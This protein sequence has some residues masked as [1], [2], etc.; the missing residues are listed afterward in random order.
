[1]EPTDKT[2][3]T[4]DDNVIL[5]LRNKNKIRR[6]PFSTPE[7]YL[8]IPYSD[9][10]AEE[11]RDGVVRD[12][13][14]L[15]KEERIKDTYWQNHEK[16]R[17]H[18]AK[19]RV[20]QEW[21]RLVDALCGS[22]LERQ[23]MKYMLSNAKVAV[24]VEEARQAVDMWSKQKADLETYTDSGIWLTAISLERSMATISKEYQWRDFVD[25]EQHQGP[26][27]FSPL[28]HALRRDGA[29]KDGVKRVWRAL[30]E[31]H[32]VLQERYMNDLS[33]ELLEDYYHRT[34]KDLGHLKGYTSKKNTKKQ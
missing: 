34:D 20:A 8:D 16:L 14:R 1:M 19:R 23:A 24:A 11:R 7:V 15:L 28:F 18:H 5:E 32:D 6:I 2:T 30:E 9:S 26:H 10:E 17:V 22:S 25:H 27:F 33:K 13:K 4:N 31:I 21:V 3:E 29:G 12:C